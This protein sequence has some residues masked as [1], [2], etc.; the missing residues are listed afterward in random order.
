[1]AWSTKKR[2]I[3][4]SIVGWGLVIIGV[5]M[6]PVMEIVIKNKIEDTVVIREG[7][8]VYE[9][10]LDP[11]VPIY[12]QIYMF[13]LT[14][15]EEFLNGAKPSLVQVGPY[16]YSE[17][18]VK[19]NISWNE[20]GT[21]T[22]RQKRIFHFLRNMSVGDDTD[23]FVSANPVYWALYNAL[24]QENPKVR[25]MVNFLTELFEEHPL[26]TRPVKELIWGYEDEILK[27]AKGI[28]PK[29]F[30]TDIIGY[31]I[32]KND[33]DD[34]VY[35]VN[36]GAKE[37]STLGVIDKYNG[38]SYLN[39]W[40]TK[41]A[42]MVNGSDGT[43]GPPYSSKDSVLY[44][45]SSDICRSVP[46]VFKKE[47]ETPQ[48]IGLWRF[49]APPNALGNSTENPDNVGFCTPNCL[50][51]GLYNISNCQTV[52]FFNVPGALSLPHFLFGDRR[53]IDAVVGLNPNE[54]EHNPVVD[55]EPYTG[56]VL[57]AFKRLQVNMHLEP[58]ANVS[59]TLGI[60]PVFLPVFWLNE[61]AV[62]DDKNAK[63]F[64]QL[65]FTPLLVIHIM[66]ILLIS[67]GALILIVTVIYGVCKYR[68]A[69][70]PGAMNADNDRQPIITYDEDLSNNHS[71]NISDP[72]GSNPG[73]GSNN[74]PDPNAGQLNP[75]NMWPQS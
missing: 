71:N 45:F 70:P 4:A 42:N 35:T 16:S 67:L 60:K 53:Y 38:S 55:F 74:I 61:S 2:V 75:D 3:V 23:L 15:Q 26:C 7:G 63:K 30:Y 12:L 36:T 27:A 41:W 65:L 56:L 19:F 64:Y 24:K 31:F 59:E 37:I 1:M 58:I 47:V 49:G 20:N 14:N 72:N 33:T 21:V 28:D 66:E 40:S 44:S 57:Q 62:I 48:G 10:W 54:E 68:S 46:G 5:V 29:W 69:L 34:G 6:I 22:Y 8:E 50:G 43:L 32:N 11:P 25:R 51:S 18:R 13:N 9:Y 52:D 17:R 73:H 39:F